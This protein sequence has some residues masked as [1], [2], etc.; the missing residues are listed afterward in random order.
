ML[1]VNFNFLLYFNHINSQTSTTKLE[2]Y[3]IKRN[4]ITLK[5]KWK[6][7]EKINKFHNGH[8]AREWSVDSQI[9]FP[10]NEHLSEIFIRQCCHLIFSVFHRQRPTLKHCYS[11]EYKFIYGMWIV[12]ESYYNLL[13]RFSLQRR[14]EYQTLSI[15]Y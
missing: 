12:V 13:F 15:E 4:Q 9:Y 14:I 8:R 5:M 7:W 11:C 1:L 10:T 3:K 2:F 6:S